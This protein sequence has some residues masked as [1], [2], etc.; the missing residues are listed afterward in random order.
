MITNK[1]VI[2]RM[3]TK[4]LM[5]LMSSTIYASLVM[6]I[7]A[8]TPLEVQAG[9]ARGA[10]SS[11]DLDAKKP[12]IYG[13]PTSPFSFKVLVA[14]AEKNLDFTLIET[15]PVKAAKGKGQTLSPEFLE[16][17]PLGKIPALRWGDFSIADSSVIIAYLDRK[18]P[19]NP[20]YP[21]QPEDFAKTLWFEKYGDEV[22]ASVVHHKILF[23]KIVKP[24]LFGKP[25]DQAILDQ[26]ITQELPE[27]LNYLD[28]ELSGK[29]WIVGN[30]FTA[31][32]IAIGNHLVSLKQCGVDISAEKWP[33]VVH[34]TQD[35][36]ARDSFKKNMA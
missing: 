5:K 19:G 16:A 29:K 27:I 3:K 25:T 28:K 34:Y 24:K 15:L 4:Y 22:V 23:E 11:T 26:A 33:N 18:A 13:V 36:F 10:E 2:E 21:S 1:K 12:I 35:L 17:S 30:Q 14:L 7:L 8:G 6:G 32:D 31:A 20:L 9:T